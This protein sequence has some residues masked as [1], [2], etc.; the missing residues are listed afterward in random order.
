MT[1]GYCCG[2]HFLFHA[3]YICILIR[4]SEVLLREWKQGVRARSTEIAL[5]RGSTGAKSSNMLQARTG[6]RSFSLTSTL[7]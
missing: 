3:R 6:H 7:Q 2:L 4:H 5:I 1:T